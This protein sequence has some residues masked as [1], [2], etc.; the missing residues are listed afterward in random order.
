VIIMFVAIMV[1]AV[2]THRHIPRLRQPPVRKF[3]AKT[4]A[5][6]MAAAMFSRNFVAL[7]GS[8]LIFGIS[9]GLS[10]GLS[11]YFSTFL[12]QLDTPQQSGIGLMALLGSVV[13]VI[14]AP[15]LS[16]RYGKKRAC[17]SLFFIAAF[18]SATPIGLKL[19]G[20]M[21]PNHTLAL[22][23][24]LGIDGMITAI[25]GI[26]GF[27]IVTSMIADMI[28]EIE[29]KSGQR[30]EG[31]LFSADTTPQKIA[32]AISI[33]APGYMLAL[34]GLPP[35]ARPHTLDPA[36]IHH[37]AQIYLPLVVGLHICSILCLLLYGIDKAR[38]EDNLRALAQSAAMAELADP[39]AVIPT[40]LS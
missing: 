24:I 26:M 6:E 30:S 7:A 32:A 1:S 31:L 3:V 37:L 28:E 11:Q 5:K 19:L 8:G 27:V 15:V 29:V 38:H 13:G 2:G 4:M 40:A 34:V 35:G 21:P 36:I 20:V 9:T 12:W 25:F 33:A 23:A 10:G 39:D 22:Y 14:L 17:V 18:A 16:R